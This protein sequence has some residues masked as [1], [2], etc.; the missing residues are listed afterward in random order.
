MS[1]SNLNLSMPFNR[2]ALH[3]LPGRA[4]FQVFFVLC[5]LLSGDTCQYLSYGAVAMLSCLRSQ[6][7]RRHS[8]KLR[9]CA[10]GCAAIG[11]LAN[12]SYNVIAHQLVREEAICITSVRRFWVDSNALLLRHAG[13]E[14]CQSHLSYQ[15]HYPFTDVNETE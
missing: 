3:G 5:N 6:E 12:A 4:Y 10:I 8:K 15:L 13:G 7:L 2:R 11:A 14:S 1:V 9:R